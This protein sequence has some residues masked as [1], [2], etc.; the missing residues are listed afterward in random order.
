V[1][2]AKSKSKGSSNKKSTG[3]PKTSKT[4]PKLVIAN[5]DAAGIDIGSREHFVGVPEGRDE[6]TVR[7]FKA[8][9]EGL[10]AMVEWLRACGITSVAMESTSVYWIPVFEKLEGAGF[11]VILVDARSVKHVPGRKSDVQD[12]QWLQQL[13]TFGLLKGAFR[14]SD[15]ICRLRTLQRHRKNM[16]EGASMLALHIQKALSEMNLYLHHVLSDITGESGLRI[17]DAILAGERDPSRLVELVDSG[18]KKSRQEIKC[19]L[20]GNY[21]EEQLFVIG[22]TLKAYRHQQDQI[23]QCDERILRELSKLKSAPEGKE[24]EKIQKAK[25][26]RTP[27]LQ[28]L[29]DELKRIIGIDLTEIPGIG[30]LA[31]LTILSEIG[32][33]MDRWRNEKAFVSWLGLSPANKISGGK[34]LSSRTR[35][36]ICRTAT[37]LRM[38]ALVIG[39]SKSDTTLGSFYRRKK[40]QIGAPKAN[41][42]T[43][44]KLACLIYRLMQNQ[45]N[46]QL[47][48]VQTYELN[49]KKHMVG[50]LRKRAAKL[51]FDL[52]ELPMAA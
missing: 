37:I 41:T 33:N 17:L 5:P 24:P 39:R 8:Y 49:F 47:Q 28:K 11:E 36:V 18:V 3:R 19:A 22:Q 46:Y 16:I 25:K 42:A 27:M 21:R 45:Q 38:A 35:K 50:S 44:R 29:A 26:Q 4:K 40:A 31:V 10:D 51:G 52:V 14:P 30:V 34:V 6:K 20:K 48:D 9:T 13:H 32:T 12:C 1:K 2:I 15:D 23:A 43:A 7:S